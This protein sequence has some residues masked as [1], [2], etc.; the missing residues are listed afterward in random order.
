M[1][2]A[3]D[4][5]YR[6]PAPAVSGRGA[7]GDPLEMSAELRHALEPLLGSDGLIVR[8]QVKWPRILVG[9]NEASHCEVRDL[10]NRLVLEAVETGDGWGPAFAR[11]FWP[12]REECVEV[13]TMGGI[14]ALVV[15]RRRGRW[16]SRIH[17]EAWDG[18]PLGVIAPR[19][20]V[21]RRAFD[22]LDPGGAELATIESTIWRPRT[23]IVTS[24]GAE[25]AAIRKRWRGWARDWVATADEYGIEFRPALTDPVLRQLLLAATLAIDLVAFENPRRRRGGLAALI[26]E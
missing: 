19:W 12:F 10:S 5:P 26:D 21:W 2:G 20:A 24:R 4:E 22:V 23:Y 14:R 7:A 16:M 3:A 11:N 13:L 18:R 17:A 15:R 8:Q 6:G 25:L 1:G 9:W